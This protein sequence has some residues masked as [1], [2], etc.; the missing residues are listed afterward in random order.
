MMCDKDRFDCLPLP[1]P[2]ALYSLADCLAFS[3]H[4]AGIAH[5]RYS[6]ELS[7]LQIISPGPAVRISAT[8][9]DGS[10]FDLPVFHSPAL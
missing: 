3:V 1:V 2:N 8:R 9:L 6:E 7:C 10:N 5:V 4:E